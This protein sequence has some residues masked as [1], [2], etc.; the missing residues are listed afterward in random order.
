[1]HMAH[2][3]RGAAGNR[4][5][6][7]ARTVGAVAGEGERPLDRGVERGAKGPQHEEDDTPDGAVRLLGEWASERGRN[8]VV[9]RQRQRQQAPTTTPHATHLG[10]VVR[11]PVRN[12]QLEDAAENGNGADGDG[13][14]LAVGALAA[15]ADVNRDALQGGRAGGS[16]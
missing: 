11:A 8:K 6:T 12:G 10:K 3:T 9:K 7:A 2:A 14:G 4:H 13:K 15:G 16:V 5:V 1:M